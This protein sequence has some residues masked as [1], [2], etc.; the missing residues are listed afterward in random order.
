MSTDVQKS[1]LKLRSIATLILIFTI[2]WGAGCKPGKD[3]IARHAEAVIIIKRLVARN[4]E[5]PMHT[6]LKVSRD[7]G[8][9]VK[10]R[11]DTLERTKLNCE[12]FEKL[13]QLIDVGR[14]L[15]DYAPIEKIGSFRGESPYRNF[16]CGL[17]GFIN[18][19]GPE[20]YSISINLDS[21]DII[22][23]VGP[24]VMKR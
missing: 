5:H 24:I 15:R 3:P 9:E 6:D 14:P 18:H 7:E 11:A 16:H 21:S 10:M 23:S 19:Q 17:T 1:T 4:A 2:L 8:A 22:M 12:D 13:R 20:P